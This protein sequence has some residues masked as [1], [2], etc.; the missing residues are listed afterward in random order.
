MDTKRIIQLLLEEFSKCFDD[1]K[2]Q[3]KRSELLL[4]ADMMNEEK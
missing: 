2:N 3:Y 1:V 4:L